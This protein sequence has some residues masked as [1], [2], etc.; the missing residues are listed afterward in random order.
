MSGKDLHSYLKERL[1]KEE[2]FLRKEI[3][4]KK[5]EV[6]NSLKGGRFLKE[7]IVQRVYPEWKNLIGE[8]D[9]TYY[10]IDVSERKADAYSDLGKHPLLVVL[11]PDKLRD[12]G[13]FVEYFGMTPSG[14]L[15][16]VKDGLIIP[17]ILWPEEYSSITDFGVQ[18]LNHW[19]E[20]EELHEKRPLVFANRIQRLFGGKLSAREWVEKY[21]DEFKEIKC[22][23]EVEVPGLGRRNALEHLCERYGFF[24]LFW[25]E[26]AKI[27]E[28]LYERYK[29]TKE[30]DLI[31]FMADFAFAGHL[32][33][34]S[35]LLYSKGSIVTA[36]QG[37]L[38]IVIRNF[39]K[40]VQM[41]G[42]RVS[43]EI[44]FLWYWFKDLKRKIKKLPTFF[45]AKIK[46]PEDR[47]RYYEMRK[48]DDKVE[49]ILQE[50]THCSNS[51]SRIVR[52]EEP[53]DRWEGTLNEVERFRELGERLVLAS[54]RL[55]FVDLV[56][57]EL[58][59][60]AVVQGLEL[61]L[62]IPPEIERFPKEV[63]KEIIYKGKESI[64]LASA[65]KLKVPLSVWKEG[66]TRIF[67]LEEIL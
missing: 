13:T 35:H 21:K 46:K 16:K 38:K 24:K 30:R 47:E 2:E 20:E 57:E 18:F 32:Y 49:E 64:Y 8:V 9:P 50:V 42:H 3:E 67:D 19:L 25:E 17:Q 31:Q 27:L 44:V 26:G 23:E 36:S 28:N 51:I 6:Q 22:D 10:R 60:T 11:P 1:E 33:R 41:F 58:V 39:N 15:K 5:K 4:Q 66:E 34:T 62:P 14:F 45:I 52:N 12:E 29:K 53:R 55:R 48:N 7:T 61:V 54:K 56:I 43:P 59:P 37:D 63:L 40:L 65:H